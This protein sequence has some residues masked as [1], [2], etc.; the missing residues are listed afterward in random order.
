MIVNVMQ[1][2]KIGTLVLFLEQVKMFALLQLA[3]MVEV[4]LIGVQIKVLT[5]YK[6]KII[7][8]TFVN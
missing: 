1:V 2:N 8:I 3:P 4:V 6:L 5:V 7:Q